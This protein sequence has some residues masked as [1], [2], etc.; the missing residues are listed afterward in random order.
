M[1]CKNIKYNVTVFSL[2]LLLNSCIGYKKTLYFQGDQQTLNPPNL[3][4]TYLIRTG[5]VLQ[6]KVVTPDSESKNTLDVDPKQSFG[7][8]N[9]YFNNYYVNDLGEIE[10]SLI[11]KV[12][13][14]GYSIKHIDSMLTEKV[15]G[16]SNYATVDVKFASFKFLAMGEFS[17]PGQYFV[18]NETCTIYEAIG[19]AG[20]ATMFSNK[21]KVQLIRTCSDGSKKIYTLDLTD[22]STFTSDNYFIQPNDIIYI[23]PQRAKTDKQNI[24]VL[25]LG[26]SMVSV[27]LLILTRI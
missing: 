14:A 2:L 6:I 13:V 7:G 25:S 8:E 11:G 16:Y 24:T 9:A 18:A 1:N 17:E 20:D 4:E 10:I 22:Y 27:L 19:I 3:N 12:H 5:D 23:P 15:Q 26:L 21:K